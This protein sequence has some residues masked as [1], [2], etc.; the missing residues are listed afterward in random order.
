M[1]GEG[2]PWS[3]LLPIAFLVFLA[4]INAGKSAKDQFFNES[5][6]PNH[7]STDD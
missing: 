2:M 4:G 5:K 1:F 6:T 3:I 7:E